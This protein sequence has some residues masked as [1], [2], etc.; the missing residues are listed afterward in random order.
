METCHDE[1]IDANHNHALCIS[2]ASSFETPRK[3]AAPQDEV[4]YFDPHGEERGCAARLEP[5]GHRRLHS[6]SASIAFSKGRHLCPLI[7]QQAVERWISAS[8]SRHCLIVVLQ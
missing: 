3:G 7:L 8:M 4:R 5:R 6:G 2:V 1:G